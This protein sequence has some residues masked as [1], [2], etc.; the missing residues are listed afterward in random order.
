MT[1]LADGQTPPPAGVVD[2]RIDPQSLMED[3]ARD[4][5]AL[6]A[7]SNRLGQA[8]KTFE[9]VTEG[10]L[11]IKLQWEAIVDEAMCAIEREML[12]HAKDPENRLPATLKGRPSRIMEAEARIRA[13]EQN[14]RVWVQ[15]VELEAE[16]RALEKWI[17]SKERA[18]SLRQSI[19]SA[20]KREAELTP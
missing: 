19:L 17:K 14:P 9:G 1:T 20:Q 7:A 15:F 6:D 16:I 2:I 4:A 11:G 18:A 3:L 10:E 12:E 5:R 8:I 13:K